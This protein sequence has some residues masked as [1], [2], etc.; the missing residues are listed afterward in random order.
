VIH[1]ARIWYL[2]VVFTLS[3]VE[4]Y[5]AGVIAPKSMTRFNVICPAKKLL[6]QMA[7]QYSACRKGNEDSCD[8]F[9]DT[10]R[11]LSPVYDCQRDFD[12]TDTVNYIVPAISLA[13]DIDALKYMKLLSELRSKNA[14]EFFAS[15]L[16]R[17]TLDGEAAEEYYYRSLRLERFLKQ[18]AQQPNSNKSESQGARQSNAPC[19]ENGVLS[20]RP[21]Q[22]AE[23]LS[24][25]NFK[26]IIGDRP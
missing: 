17:S 7:I 14:Q 18:K 1:V 3:A 12:S 19:Q 11:T 22:P 25:E 26:I 6:P 9:V 4:C 20:A 24:S 10:F 23:R 5:G 13:G 21:R 2:A 8:A 15:K 16:F